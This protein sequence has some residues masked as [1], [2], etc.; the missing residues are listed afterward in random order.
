MDKR[1]LDILKILEEHFP[2]AKSELKF[3]TPYQLLV[4]VV[5]SAM[6]RRAL[7]S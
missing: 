4:A 7:A 6:M 2:D 1:T 3:D 5:L